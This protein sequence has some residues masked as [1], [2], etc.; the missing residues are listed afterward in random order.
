MGRFRIGGWILIL[1]ALAACLPPPLTPGTPSP[2]PTAVPTSTPSPT[3]TMTPTPSPTATATSTPTP[4]PTA[5]KTPTPPAP[6]SSS[7]GSSGGEAPPLPTIPGCDL[8][9]NFGLLEAPTPGK[10]VVTFGIQSVGGTDCPAPTTLSLSVPSGTMSF[11]AASPAY[12]YNG[13]AGW[14]CSGTTC[15]AAGNIPA[16]PPGFYAAGF[17]TVATL[18]SGSAQLCATVSNSADGNAAND[19]FCQT[20]P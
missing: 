10:Y 3:A 5:T 18:S 11:T 8:A 9:A 19:T 4:A 13:S 17:Q 12:E 16:S 14:S 6:M 1:G 15:V 20:L 2:S 7:S